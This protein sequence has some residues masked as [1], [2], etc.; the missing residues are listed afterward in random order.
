VAQAIGR[1]AAVR[2]SAR[3]LIVG[4]EDSRLRLPFARALAADGWEVALVAPVEDPE[5]LGSEFKVYRYVLNRELAP[6]RDFLTFLQL[7]ILFRKLRPQVVQSFDTKPSIYSPM[8]A[9]AARVPRRVRTLTGLGRVYADGGPTLVRRFYETL[10]KLASAASH[11]T[12]FQNP[13]DRDLFVDRGLV[14]DTKARVFLGSGLDIAAWTLLRG[15]IDREDVRRT[16]DWTDRFVLLLAARMIW[17]KGVGVLL[18]AVRNFSDHEPKLKVVLAGPIDENDSD[19]IPRAELERFG[20]SV[21]Y[22]GETS[23]LGPIYAAADAFVLPTYYREG[24]P[25]ALMEAGIMG[26]PLITT[27][28]PGCRKVVVPG[29]GGF[30]VQSRSAESLSEAIEALLAATDAERS[31][32]GRFNQQYISENFDLKKIVKQYLDLYRSA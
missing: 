20:D 27:D 4:G 7:F 1:R 26:L 32:M 17:S 9:W 31:S 10:Q 6:F 3:L 21:D 11:I 25:R 16:M 2:R 30:L 29:K 8:A 28:T 24:V 23:D 18:Q 5:L 15:G 22:I 12:V 14:N 13:D 19:A